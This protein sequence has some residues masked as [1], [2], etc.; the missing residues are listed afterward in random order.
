MH[1]RHRA[2]VLAAMIA[3]IAWVCC[4]ALHT[5]PLSDG[6]AADMA[7]WAQRL[8]GSDPLHPK[9]DP[10]LKGI[11]AQSAPVLA[12]A[13]GALAQEH[14]SLALLRWASVRSD[15]L[16]GEA[17]SRMPAAQRSDDN[18][19]AT[20]FKEHEGELGSPVGPAPLA[21]IQPAVLRG[22]AEG[23]E[24]EARGYYRSSLDY[25][26]STMAQE[27]LFYLRKGVAEHGFAQL[28]QRLSQPIPGKSAST[29]RPL[30]GE[31]DAVEAELVRAY[32]PPFS[33]DRHGEFITASSLLKEARELDAAGMRAGALLRLL[34]AEFALPRPSAP[35]A[36]VNTEAVKRRLDQWG[37]EWSAAAADQSIGLLFVDLGHEELTRN[38]RAS[39]TLVESV[40]PLYR[41]ALAPAEPTKPKAPPEVTVT[42]VRWPYT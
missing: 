15:L 13:L 5:S 39:A 6:A 4:D 41:H 16:A 7:P 30:T 3:T 38:P 8:L 20:E 32:R 14:R 29:L 28:C 10:N 9:I 18:G 12:S 17:L 23:A 11:A 26:R 34:Q 27:G 35:N 2:L 42:L 21:A 40:L 33:V 36:S 24:L 37:R 22:M 1:S 31:L 19:L 25:G